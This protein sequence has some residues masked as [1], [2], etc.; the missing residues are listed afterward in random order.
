MALIA[1]SQLL[2]QKSASTKQQLIREHFEKF[3]ATHQK[4][5][6]SPSE[7]EYRFKVFSQNMEE[8]IKTNSANLSYKFGVNRFSD[9]SKEE[10]K[11]KYLGYRADLTKPEVPSIP[12]SAIL[13]APDSIDWRTKG[14]VTYVK[15]QGQCGSC[16]SFS[17]TGSLE[18][19]YFFKKG[20]LLAFS[21]QQLVDCSWLHGNHGCNGGLPN[22]AF[23]YWEE[24]EFLQEKDY[25]YTARDG[26]CQYDSK[27]KYGM[28]KVS[29]FHENGHT[30]D[31]LLASVAETPTSVGVYAV[32]W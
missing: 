27:K 28:G 11:A 16:W 21:E 20:Q 23:K 1:G 15:D 26:H 17:A 29:K 9:L 10:F 12:A 5:Y 3:I 18:A 2:N 6:A 8:V 30:E 4:Q 31:D 13:N 19:Q 24:K 14:A 25:F 7:K 22:N 32:P